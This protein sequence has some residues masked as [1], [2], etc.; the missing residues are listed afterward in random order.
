MSSNLLLMTYLK[1]LFHW[2][3]GVFVLLSLKNVSEQA[4]VACVLVNKHTFICEY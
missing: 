2:H 4:N 3:K 1:S